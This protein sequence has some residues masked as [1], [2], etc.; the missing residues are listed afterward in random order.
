MT[1]PTCI[2]LALLP[3]AITAISACNSSSNNDNAIEYGE[4]QNS[5][6]ITPES[7]NAATKDRITVAG[8]SSAVIKALDVSNY[9]EGGI[10]PSLYLLPNISPTQ[11]PASQ[12]RPGDIPNHTVT[13]QIG[14]EAKGF[15]ALHGDTRNSDEVQSVAAPET[16]LNWIAEKNLF[17]YEGGVFD[18]N[19][20]V[21]VAPIDPVEDVYLVSIDGESGER[22]WHL[23]GKRMGQ[24]GAPLIL[25]AANNPDE[26]VI[27]IGSYE[28][29]T[30][31]NSQGE[32]M[33]DVSTGLTLPADASQISTH[34]FGIN[35]H[36]QS[37]SVVA[38]Y[39]DG[40]MVVHDRDTGAPRSEPFSLPGSNTKPIAYETDF[41]MLEP[42]VHNGL[43]KLF[44]N[45]QT[46][47]DV[48]SM[49]LGGGYEVSNYFGVDPNT[50]RIFVGATAPDEADGEK[51]GLSAF[52]ALY[53]LD[54]NDKGQ[55][56]I[57]WRRDFE[58]GTAATP[59]LSFDGKVVYTADA[60]DKMLAINAQDGELIWDYATGSGQVVGSVSISREGQEIYVSTAVDIIKLLDMGACAG[61][62]SLCNKPVWTAKLDEAFDSSVLTQATA[63]AQVY[64]SALKPAI[65]GF[66]AAVGT[67]G[68]EFK[69][70]AG[71]M[72]LAGV[73]ANGIVA[74][75]GFGYL[76]PRG[77]VMPFQIS[78]VL[79]DRETGDI[80]YSTPGVEES[81][82]VMALAP[83]GNLYM[84]NSA[85]RRILNVAMIRAVGN[86]SNNP[87]LKYFGMEAL[88]GIAQFTQKTG[89]KIRVA[90]EAAEAAYYRIDNLITKMNSL[91]EG[92]IMAEIAR[93]QTL[94]GQFSLSLNTAHSQ[95]EIN[96]AA[97]Q[98]GESTLTAATL[99]SSSDL[100]KAKTALQ[101]WLNI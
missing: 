66:Y 100:P 9:V 7:V 82:S 18:R 60:T 84:S 63:Q 30:A 92:A 31:V 50:G 43:S 58:G 22:R 46:F 37:N 20:N 1:F 6:A 40:S 68:F 23:S 5:R 12:W 52:G 48:L 83:N 55:L 35:Y 28:Y 70:A 33:W 27:Y 85:L 8:H 80:R 62:G 95:G 97:L 13:Q 67:T 56:Q 29:I 26:D 74:Q 69:A 90:Q 61:D 41:S 14:S 73:T 36:P 10:D 89:T 65:E 98:T 101:G 45:T 59:T 88:G 57:A 17:S 34:N 15:Y 21:Y 99:T 53:A 93:I 75:A 79:L 11:A 24:G 44:E 25:P 47:F 51:D 87:Q 54:L 81:V 94:L 16:I 78:Q 96:D 39:A 64:A 42:L 3:L 72:V 91:D 38:V 76:S 2:K 77:S 49:V 71:N 4:L 19:S 32:V 86:N